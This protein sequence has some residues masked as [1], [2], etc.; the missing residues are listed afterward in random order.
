MKGI[1]QAKRKPISVKPA[2]E[3]GIDDA[4]LEQDKMLVWEA[5]ELP[6]ERGGGK[7]LDGDAEESAAELARLLHEDAKVI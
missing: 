5:L 6:P 2:A 4:Q 3:L 7:I 1:M